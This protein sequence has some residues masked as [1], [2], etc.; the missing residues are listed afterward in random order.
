MP[1]IQCLVFDGLP[2]IKSQAQSVLDMLQQPSTTQLQGA[3]SAVGQDLE[4]GQMRAWGPRTLYRAACQ[5]LDIL[6]SS[7][8]G[9]ISD[10]CRQI[11]NMH[12]LGAH[13]ATSLPCSWADKG[14]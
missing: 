7:P 6:F 8:D 1:V 11:I 9:G 2:S 5:L 10:T 3:G 12:L 13:E 4:D 14:H